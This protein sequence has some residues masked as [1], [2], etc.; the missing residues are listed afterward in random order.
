MKKLFISFILLILVTIITP[1][2]SKVLTIN[3]STG[4][5]K[6]SA[7]EKKN[8]LF[9]SSEQLAKAL[10]G[11]TY[12]NSEAAKLE[13]KFPEWRVK[14]TG[15]NQFVIL[16]PRFGTNREI[17]QLPIS[18][19]MAG[20]DIYIPLKYC[21]PHLQKAIGKRM[22][23]DEES[24]KLS[25]DGALESPHPI[26]RRNEGNA[27]F[28][29]SGLSISEKLNG[30]LISLKAKK[31]L[32]KIHFSIKD[33]TGYLFLYGLT[34]DPSLTSGVKPTGVV[35]DIRQKKVGANTQIEFPI[36]GDYKDYDA[37]QDL[38]SY[39]IYITIRKELDED[40][41]EEI[42]FDREKWDFD[43]I[44]L[45]AG[46]GGKDAG[47]IGI[48][49]TREKDINL[50][51]TLELGKL[52]EQKMDSVKVVYTRKT[53]KFVELHE[54]GKIANKN[55]G[56]LFISIHCN[57]IGGKNHSTRGFEV[58]LLRPGRTEEAIAIAEF[59]NSVIKYEENPDIYKQ[60][61]DENFILVS[62]AHSSYMRYSEKFSEYL[63]NHWIEH[64]DIPSRGV[65]QAGF[66]VLVGASMPGVLV[67][68]GFLSNKGDERYLKS[69]KGQREIAL[70]IFKAIEK[71]KEYYENSFADGSTVLSD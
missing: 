38:T 29:I 49:G 20:K 31:N 4:S 62:M 44:V 41:K 61:D 13:M 51:V 37:F 55:N 25:F 39:D 42:K 50:A 2:Q 59:E 34:V 11:A 48:T 30:T 3:S 16:S 53:D 70:A 58:Y 23:L 43:V 60:L 6:V 12:Y 35:K 1:A 18:T 64:V 26:V 71:Y 66:Y 46:H 40:K 22:V 65:K 56:K 8:V 63:N 27:R 57:S 32:G 36:K 5:R 68:N 54:R 67:E 9:V 21:I 15:R 28:D 69:K 52:I 45:D 7:Y 17:V 10:G 24:A 33:N 19:L 47:A 14:Y